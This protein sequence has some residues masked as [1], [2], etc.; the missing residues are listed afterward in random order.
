MNA[1]RGG[2]ETG[3]PTRNGQSFIADMKT[4]YTNFD[5][6]MRQL[7]S[8]ATAKEARFGH[9]PMCRGATSGT[10]DNYHAQPGRESEAEFKEGSY[11]SENQ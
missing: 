1:S 5:K 7:K 11:I 4:I 3:R 8:R 10:F 6:K 2:M 9:D